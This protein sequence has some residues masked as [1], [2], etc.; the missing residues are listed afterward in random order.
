MLFGRF[1]GKLGSGTESSDWD[2][3][4]G[5]ETGSRILDDMLQKTKLGE[6]DLVG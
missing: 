1:L 3:I 5:S 2:R 6:G 4:Q